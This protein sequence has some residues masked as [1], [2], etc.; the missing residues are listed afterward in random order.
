MEKKF[1]TLLKIKYGSLNPKVNLE[2]DFFTGFDPAR[3][4]KEMADRQISS[5]GSSAFTPAFPP[6]MDLKSCHTRIIK[7]IAIP[8]GT[9]TFL[10][11]LPT[12]ENNSSNNE[13]LQDRSSVNI[14]VISSIIS[15]IN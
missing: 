6:N 14:F 12:T 8:V 9:I 7:R 15:T 13:R 5:I 2:P 4:K 11:R 3:R 10:Y 1:E